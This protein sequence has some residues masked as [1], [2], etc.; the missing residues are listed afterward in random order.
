MPT[1]QIQESRVNTMPCVDGRL[2]RAAAINQSPATSIVVSV[3]TGREA[4]PRLVRP[5]RPTLTA[6]LRHDVHARLRRGDREILVDVGRLSSIDA[7]GVGQLVRAY[8]ITRARKAELRVANPAPRVREVLER[9]G[10]LDALSA[11]DGSSDVKVDLCETQ[12]S[13]PPSRAV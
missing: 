4:T 12:A 10:L 6:E 8:N 5:Y 11:G 3:H 7:A 1:S 9:V 13:I 2:S